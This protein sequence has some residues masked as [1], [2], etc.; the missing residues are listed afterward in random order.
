MEFQPKFGIQL[1]IPIPMGINLEECI[2]G[3]NDSAVGIQLSGLIK[4]REDLDVQLLFFFA[5]YIGD[6]LKRKKKP[7]S[8]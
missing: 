2:I 7:E 8:S 5:P 1:G 4:F 6:I 3:T